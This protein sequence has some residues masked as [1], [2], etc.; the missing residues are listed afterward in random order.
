[1]KFVVLLD[2]SASGEKT[3]RKFLRSVFSDESA[4]QNAYVVIDDLHEKIFL[5]LGQNISRIHRSVAQRSAR[6]ARAHGHE[7]DKYVVGR[8]FDVIEISEGEEPPPEF[9]ELLKQKFETHED[10][11]V[12]VGAPE[13]V[14]KP[15]EILKIEEEV[16]TEK[17]V[18]IPEVVVIP[19]GVGEPAKNF[20][21][22]PKL[23]ELPTP[24]KRIYI[25]GLIQDALFNIEPKG[26]V[27]RGDVE[28]SFILLSKHGELLGTILLEPVSKDEL[29]YKASWTR[30]KD[31]EQFARLLAKLTT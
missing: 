12:I 15:V 13:I 22:L 27:S 14:R 2:I 21:I 1:M 24:K 5:F 6:F 17:K 3:P 26:M 10:Y 7:V 31:G 28:N 11:S 4:N 29:V 9:G 23:M 19:E 20:V 16:E 8:N 30:D 25:D 18:S